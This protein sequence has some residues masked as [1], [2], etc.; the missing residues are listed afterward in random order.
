MT[1]TKAMT[2]ISYNATSGL[3]PTNRW[4][5][6]RSRGGYSAGWM[7]ALNF[8][9]TTLMNTSVGG[10]VKATVTAVDSILAHVNGYA[11]IGDS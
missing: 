7:A 3:I 4:E 6:T 2:A 8:N 5:T 9:G 10:S 1:M 11:V